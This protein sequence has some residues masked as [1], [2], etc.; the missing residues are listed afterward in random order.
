MVCL[1]WSGNYNC[2]LILCHHHSKRTNKCFHIQ[3]QPFKKK[4]DSAGLLYMKDGLFHYQ[5]IV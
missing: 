2:L 4:C 5:L 3:I 1:H